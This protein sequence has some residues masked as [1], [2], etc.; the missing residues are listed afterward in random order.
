MH[1]QGFRNSPGFWKDFPVR[2]LIL[3]A[4]RGSGLYPFTETRP[5]AMVPVAGE[6]LL[7]GTLE[8]LRA[9]GVSDVVM[10]IGHC[11]EMIRNRFGQG[12]RGI[13]I[14][15]V[16]QD[17]PAG[18]GDAIHR[19]RSFF[20]KE[21]VF[22]LVYA[23]V[24]TIGNI[25]RSAI[26]TFGSFNEPVA[27]I[28]HTPQAQY[29]GTVYLDADMRISR[30]VEKPTSREMGNY[31]LAG[32]FVMP[33]RLFDLLEKKNMEESLKEIIGGEGIRSA[34]WEEPWIDAHHPWDLLRAN[35]MV[36]ETWR[37]A[38]VDG[39]VQL[40]GAVQF[41]GP[42]RIEAGVVI[43]S[44]ASIF[45][46]C[47]IGKESFI[48]NGVLVRPYTAVGANAMIGFGVELK[49]CILH[50]GVKVGRLS[51]IGDSVIGEGVEFG[52][53]SMTVNFNMDRSNVRL[54]LKKGSVDSG[55]AKLGAFVGDG[56][57]I[58]ASNTLAPGTV[59]AGGE[60]VPNYHT[61]P[62]GGA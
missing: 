40:R 58:G 29:F 27:A 35:R 43:E 46:P 53:G 5:K 44:G 17:E 16:Q 48:G 42:V 26:Q 61:H 3:A 4:G 41:R 31:V 25:F 1:C 45:G 21:E 28:C 54:P 39:S 51:F 23:D 52:S 50:D 62:H 11:G 18:I 38:V 57:R 49:N 60:T 12:A 37:K 9:A 34:I 20:Q 55:L 56:A 15:Y 10:V 6:V 13:T 19:A 14:Q 24:F 7:E 2:A 36:M 47:H 32:V 30:L 22:L 33:H 59:I 8:K